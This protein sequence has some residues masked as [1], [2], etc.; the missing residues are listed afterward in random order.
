MLALVGPSGC[1]KTTTLRLLSG[2]EE[3]S[4]GRI[5]FAD[6]PMNGVAPKERD[7]A[8]VFQNPALYPH[9]TAR[10]N[11]VFGLRLRKCPAGELEQRLREAV[12]VLGLADCLERRPAE[13]SGGQCQRVALGR[14]LVRRP[15]VFLFDEPLSNLD[16]QMRG[17]LRAE[18]S[19]L[20]KRLAAT[21]IYVTHDQV[22]AMMLGDRIAVMNRGR[23][24]QVGTAR[25]LYRR[26]RN[27]FVG[28]FIGPRGMN[29]FPGSL[30]RQG[31]ELWFVEAC[32]NSATQGQ[33]L[34]AR[35]RNQSLNGLNEHLDKPVVLGIRPEALRLTSGAM[36]EASNGILSAV[37]EF[38]EPSGSDCFVHLRR[39][40]DV[41][42]ARAKAAD[43]VSVGQPV[44]AAVD[45]AEAH[46]FDAASGDRISCEF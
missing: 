12:E 8:M 45:L 7:V 15:K 39:D 40:S 24:Q 44:C 14:A 4:S 37:V 23:I 32:A 16:P 25:E 29:F 33:T 13:L 36:N 20:H 42:I 38:L 18:I 35:C 30:I 3:P 17:Q 26:P 34:K 10:E 41:L 31:D 27:T 46:F 2:L 9:M 11:I 22:E 21:S 5:T 19:R 1:G 6:R 43:V 28:G